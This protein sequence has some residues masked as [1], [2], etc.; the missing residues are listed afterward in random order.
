MDR[1]QV[2]LGCGKRFLHGFIHVD[3]A[4]FSHIDYNHDIQ[5]LPMFANDQVDLIY[6]SHSFEYFD[7]FQVQQVLSEWH[8]ILK[9][10]GILRLA[11]PDFEALIQVYKETGDLD[12]ILGPLYGRW[13]VSEN[14]SV[15]H[16]TI[17]DKL[18]LASLLKQKGFI[19]IQH[20]DWQEV[21]I[22]KNS[23]YD[24]F[25]QA[26]YPHMDKENGLLI[27]LNMEGKKG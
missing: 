11:V 18:S 9:P 4:D 13:Q 12:S 19:D 22:G 16:R 1:I 3:L 20:W 6:A 21:F 10:G 7:R 14:L 25:S 5:S 24:D 23:G 15:Y 27:S 2:H 26:Y 8:R 17:Y